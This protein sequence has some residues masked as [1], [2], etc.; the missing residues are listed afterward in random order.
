MLEIVLESGVERAFCDLVGRARLAKQLL[1][2]SSCSYVYLSK[3]GQ[4]GVLCLKSGWNGVY[5]LEL[6]LG[7]VLEVMNEKYYLFLI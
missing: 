5:V 2:L 7:F 4:K 3:L 6:G 1:L